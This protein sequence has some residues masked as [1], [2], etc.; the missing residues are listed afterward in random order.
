M[1]GTIINGK[2]AV[3]RRLGGGGMA[4]VFAGRTVGA[5]GFARPVAIKRVLDGF[6]MRSHPEQWEPGRFVHPHDACYDHDGNIFVV[7]W[8]A[9]GRVSKLVKVA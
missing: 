2:Y 7:E 6:K 5:E 8:V 4:E 9:T 1:I 3:D